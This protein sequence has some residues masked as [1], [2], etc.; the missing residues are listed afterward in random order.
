[1]NLRTPYLLFLGD[2][3]R[4][5][6]AQGIAYWRPE[7]CAGQIRLPGGTA[8]LGLEAMTIAEAARRGVGTLVI[9][10][11]PHGGQLPPAWVQVIV[12]ALHAGLDV[13]SGLHT[14]VA[15]EPRVSEA[16]RASGRSVFD[17][18]HST[19]VFP[20]ATGL[21]RSGHRLLTVGTDCEAGKMYTSLALEAEMRRRGVPVD[22]RATGQTGILIA[23]TGVAVDAVVSDFVAGATEWLA[24]ANAADHWDVIEGQGSLFHPA[25]AGVTLGLVHGSQAEALVLCHDAARRNVIGFPTYPLPT[26]AECIEAY[27]KAA[28]LTR[29]G[30]RCIGLSINTSKLDAADAERYLQRAEAATGLPCIDPVR[31]S[32]ARLV[33]ALVARR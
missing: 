18:R 4:A 19:E 7:R 27:E 31:G 26:F 15:L 14:R 21:P 32:V 23:G 1:M 33:D 9:G 8:D 6:T 12:D 20:I 29:P 22:F 5:K 2:G 13:A 10:V 17:V 28:R 11:A 24:P 30:S 25:Y 3:D 16:A